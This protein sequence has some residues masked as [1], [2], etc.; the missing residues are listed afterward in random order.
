MMQKISNS[1]AHFQKRTNTATYHDAQASQNLKKPKPITIAS[2]AG[3]VTQAIQQ[4]TRFP[5]LSTIMACHY[6][7]HL[8]YRIAQ[9]HKD[10]SA[11]LMHPTQPAISLSK[12]SHHRRAKSLVLTTATSAL[13]FTSA[14]TTV[15]AGTI[16]V[17]NDSVA[18][19]SVNGDGCDLAEAIITAHRYDLFSDCTI[20]GSYYDF[21]IELDNRTV[22]LTEPFGNYNGATGLPSI[23]STVTIQNGTIQRDPTADYFRIFHLDGEGEAAGSLTLSNVTVQGGYAYSPAA[24]LAVT[25]P[26]LGGITFPGG[27]SGTGVIVIPLATTDG[28]NGGGFFVT[29]S[30][31]LN[32]TNNSVIS[33]NVAHHNGGGI[34][35]N[36]SSRVTIDNSTLVQNQTSTIFFTA[37]GGGAFITG[38][39]EIRIRNQSIITGNDA[40]YAGGG[41]ALFNSTA[42]I[43]D[44]QIIRNTAYR[45]QAYDYGYGGGIYA[46][47]GTVQISN[48]TIAHNVSAYGGG[49]NVEDGSTATVDNSL[50]FSNTALLDGGGI[51]AYDNSNLALTGHSTVTANLAQD[52]GGGA[53]VDVS[54]HLTVIDSQ[55]SNNRARD[56]GGGLM[57]E[58]SAYMTVT[59]SL[60]FGNVAED[61]GGGL[62]AED[63]ATMTITNSR[64]FSNMSVDNGGG[65]AVIDNSRA[66]IKGA[67]QIFTNTGNLGGGIYIRDNSLLS[68]TGASIVSDNF[69]SGDGGGLYGDEFSHITI[70]NATFANNHVDFD[71]GAIDIEDDTT[72]R[73]S[74]SHFYG[75]H[76]G[77]EGGAIAVDDHSF[78]TISAATQIFSNTA[79]LG[80]G[81]SIDER[82]QVTVTTSSIISNNRAIKGGGILMWDNSTLYTTDSTITGNQAS[83][84]GGGV[85]GTSAVTITLKGTAITYNIAGT[86]GGGLYAEEALVTVADSTMLYNTATN[87]GDAIYNDDATLNVADSCIVGN[88]DTSF[89]SMV[90]ATAQR[91]WWGSADGPSGQFTGAGDSV[92]PNID[93]SNYRTT[94]IL[95]CPTVGTS[96]FTAPSLSINNVTANEDAGALLFT[97]SLSKRSANITSVSYRTENVTA[98]A[99]TSFDS[100]SGTLTFAAGETQKTISV[101]IHD[102][103]VA[104]GNRTMHL[105]LSGSS[106]ASIADDKGVGT[107]LDTDEPATATPTVSPTPTSTPTSTSTPT[108]T[109][110]PTPTTTPPSTPVNTAT[111]TITPTSLPTLTPAST[112]TSSPMPSPTLTPA[113][114]HTSTPMPTDTPTAIPTSTPVPTHSPTLSPTS[115]ST[116]TQTPILTLTPTSTPTLTL[117]AT[118]LPTPTLTSTPTPTPVPIEFTAE[119]DQT[120][121]EAGGEIGIR[122]RIENMRETPLENA[123]LI[124]TVPDQTTWV[125][126]VLLNLGGRSDQTQLLINEP[127]SDEPQSDEQCPQGF[128]AGQICT[129]PIGDIPSGTIRTIP[130]AVRVND[131]AALGSTVAN[132]QAQLDATTSGE[133]LIMDVTE[134]VNVTVIVTEPTALEETDEPRA[135]FAFLPLVSH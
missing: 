60:V 93:Y 8:Q 107:I 48:S 104:Q 94:A 105:V 12:S 124:V 42:T 57:V 92:G 29:N 84:K 99:G 103:A 108:A 47:N 120:T 55:V 22:T 111:P 98:H 69:A 49:I 119:S 70:D 45:S 67:S 13:L 112:A 52:D 9:L 36:G 129:I 71:G 32:V 64:V 97:V 40:S 25:R 41:V 132:I 54:S 1:H 116:P 81:I 44:S 74:A 115:T 18:V 133:P 77:D 83:T 37:M 122:F 114:T 126:D 10:I 79:D 72:L 14:V 80:G 46:D 75:N 102:L 91:N 43:A 82:S 7:T 39:S 101:P 90:A 89:T 4:L 134:N 31:R 66:L 2:L 113:P 35:A 30:G 11:R 19:P 15:Q 88:G 27:G 110:T 63:S 87:N 68:I 76:G 117:A 23:T 21:T 109:S 5:K 73:V 65:I 17:T 130:I 24:P 128:A 131:D 121:A 123:S 28:Y 50:I 51:A 62:M 86:T 127:Q 125:P 78:A 3:T 20:D 58:N 6:I 96:T 106:N 26:G 59:N 56:D 85:Y 33:G 16:T 135:W 118:P 34:Y 100:T 61:N 53:Y 38:G 95:G